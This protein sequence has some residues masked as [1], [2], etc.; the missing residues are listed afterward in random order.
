MTISLVVARSG[1]NIAVR[2][3]AS[4]TDYLS[5]R[6]LRNQSFESLT[7]HPYKIGLLRQ[8]LFWFKRK[9]NEAY[10][11]ALMGEDVCYVLLAERPDGIYITIVCDPR[12]RSLGIG[13]YCLNFIVAMAGKRSKHLKAEIQNSNVSSIRLFKKCG[14]AFY[15]QKED[16]RFFI[17]GTSPNQLKSEAWQ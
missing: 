9:R 15:H 14:F 8:V 1:T 6:R 4:I 11:F 10:I 17:H 16:R 3:A 5:L 12:Y 13:T 2:R 7:N